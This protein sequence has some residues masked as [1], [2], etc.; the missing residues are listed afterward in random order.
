MSPSAGTLCE[1]DIN[2]CDSDPCQNGATCTDGANFYTCR[3]PAPAPGEE[4][5]GGRDCQVR[6]VGC[7]RH[8]CQHG[9]GCVPLLRDSGEQGYSC[10]CSSGW[11]GD[12]CNTSTTFSFGSDGFVHVQTP[13]P[14]N[15]TRAEAG[16]HVHGL[17]VQLRFRSTLPNALLFRRGSAEHYASLELLEGSLLAKVKSGKALQVAYPGPVNDGEWHQVTVSMDESLLLA[18]KGPACEEECQVKSEGHNYLI[19][20]QPSSFQQLYVGGAPREDPSRAASHPSFIGCMEDLRVDGKLLL[21]QDLLREENQGLEFGCNK[22]DW[23]AGEPCRQ[24]G[25]CVD[26]WV[27]ALCACRRPYYGGACE[28]GESGRPA[29]LLW[30]E[31]APQPKL[32]PGRRSGDSSTPRGGEEVSVATGQGGTVLVSLAWVG[33]QDE[34]RRPAEPCR[35]REQRGN[36]FAPSS[37]LLSWSLTVVYISGPQM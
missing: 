27:R 11:A 34:E 10:V 25:R 20:L 24:R 28:K 23:C 35:T 5:W 7:R 26:M 22:Q 16:D 4:P 9:A 31:C 17:H 15:R 19:F 1:V 14:P 13:L 36:C 8:R 2:E 6:L 3:C 37:R 21:P 12:L 18:V 29:C 30:Q 32:L 33:V